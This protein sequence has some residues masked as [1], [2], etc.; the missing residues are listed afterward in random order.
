M[1]ALGVLVTLGQ[2]DAIGT[3][4]VVDGAYVLTIRTDDF[5]MLFDLGCIYHGRSP[6]G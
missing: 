6:A 1:L 3:F 2:L 4:H 5:R